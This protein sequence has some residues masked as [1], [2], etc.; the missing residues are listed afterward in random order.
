MSPLS[1]SMTCTNV[2]PCHGDRVLGQEGSGQGER[3]GWSSP[4]F[5]IWNERAGEKKQGVC[6]PSSSLRLS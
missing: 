5:L 1:P 3:P 6:V 2:E 4:V